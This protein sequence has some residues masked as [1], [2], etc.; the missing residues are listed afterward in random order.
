LS[1]HKKTIDSMRKEGEA[2]QL[3]RMQPPPPDSILNK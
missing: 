3:A 1:K 2:Q